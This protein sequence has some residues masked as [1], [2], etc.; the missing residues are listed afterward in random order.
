MLTFLL[1]IVVLV[2]LLAIYRLQLQG[3]E[4]GILVAPMSSMDF[5]Q[6]EIP[7]SVQ[8]KRHFVE[9]KEYYT[10]VILCVIFLLV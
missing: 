5:L 10:K 2:P 7:S 9:V 6:D 3:K 8:E 1:A 4:R